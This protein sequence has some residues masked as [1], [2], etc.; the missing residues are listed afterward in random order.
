MIGND[1]VDCQQRLC[2]RSTKITPIIGQYHSGYRTR[3]HQWFCKITRFTAKSHRWLAKI[4]PII[5][6]NLNDGW[7]AETTNEFERRWW[8]GACVLLPL[9]RS[10]EFSALRGKA[11]T[12]LLELHRITKQFITWEY[13]FNIFNNLTTFS[14]YQHI[15][16]KLL[17]LYTNMMDSTKNQTSN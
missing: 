15:Q 11:L 13:Q 1:D 16:S 14:G 7:S 6:Q 12:T 8:P 5:C 4:T 17:Q 10:W 2:S 3:S 9:S